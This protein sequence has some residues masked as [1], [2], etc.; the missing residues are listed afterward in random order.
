MKKKIHEECSKKNIYICMFYLQKYL[1]YYKMQTV[2]LQCQPRIYLENMLLILYSVSEHKTLS[3]KY[4][5][6]HYI[7][8]LYE[9]LVV[10]LLNQSFV[11]H[12]DPKKRIAFC[13]KNKR[14]VNQNNVASVQYIYLLM[15]NK[16]ELLIINREYCF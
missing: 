8:F 4:H 2:D 7:L 10:S 5:T 14:K 6:I 1:K 16:Q 13:E 15:F 9:P 11:I 12:S 3:Q